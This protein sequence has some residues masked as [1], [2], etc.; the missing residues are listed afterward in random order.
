MV[1][2]SEG[3]PPISAIACGRSHS[4]MLSADG[5]TVFAAGQ[6][7]FS[8]CGPSETQLAA[9]LWRSFS[10]PRRAL[11]LCSGWE[12]G[13]V[14]LEPS[15]DCEGSISGGTV[16][17]WGRGDHGQLATPLQNSPTKCSQALV[18]VPVDNIRDIACGSNHTIALS[19]LSNAVY[20]WGWNEHGNAG[21]PSLEDVYQPLR[22]P[23]LNGS[24][25]SIGCGYG[26]SYIV[27]N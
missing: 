21:D 16:A 3:L 17:M 1:L 10:L 14:L 11:K 12:F 22:V 23:N 19:A 8:Q 26:N 9:G 2:V 24:V 18:Y 27:L 6:N 25:Q 4:F 7:K 20:M 15:V 5:R 13:A